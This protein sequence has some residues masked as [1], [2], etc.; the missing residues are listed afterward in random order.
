M[1]IGKCKFCGFTKP[2]I[3]PFTGPRFRVECA[4]CGSFGWTRKTREEAIQVWNYDQIPTGK[5]KAA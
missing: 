2:K 4:K 5:S 1:K 3:E